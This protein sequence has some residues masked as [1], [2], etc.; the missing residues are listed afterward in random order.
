MLN[1][2]M[3]IG[4]LAADPELR[5]TQNGTPVASF[6]IATTEKWKDQ[7]GQ[8]QEQTEWHNIVAWRRL[9]EICDEHLSKGA[10]V[11]IEGKLQTRKW[12]D[13]HGNDRYK[14]EIIA[15]EMKMLDSRAG[16]N[17]GNKGNG[18]GKQERYQ[19]PMAGDDVPF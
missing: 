12:Q 9:A 6:R 3:L 16:G 17:G 5:Y 19:A 2:V 1:K 13:Q 15:S 4:N 14:T 10:K 7:D 18:N 11:Y 8:A